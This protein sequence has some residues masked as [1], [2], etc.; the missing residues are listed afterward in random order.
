MPGLGLGTWK[1]DPGV[2]G[3][4]IQ[5]A[6]TVG[7][8]HIDCAAIYGNEAEIGVALKEVFEGGIVQR[9]DLFLTSKLWNAEHAP[10]DVEPALRARHWRICRWTVWT[11]T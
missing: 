6:I 3:E 10:E 11:C 2:V 1:S 7:Y 8:R 5:T 9:E 4:S